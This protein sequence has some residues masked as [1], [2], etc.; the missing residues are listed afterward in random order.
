MRLRHSRRRLSLAAASLAAIAAGSALRLTRIGLPWWFVKYGGAIIWG[1]MVYG[2]VA[3]LA[4][5]AR[6]RSVVI[7][8]LLVAIASE[9]FRLYHSPGLDAFR[10]TLPGQLLLGRIFSAW[11]IVAYAVGIGLAAWIDRA[12]G[13]PNVSE[14][15]RR[16]NS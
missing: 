16:R 8:A 12:L 5:S 13:V 9:L 2:L 6:T 11:N 4:A 10:L 1:M 15:W 3:L 7:L 14:T